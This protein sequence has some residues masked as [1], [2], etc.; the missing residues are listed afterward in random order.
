MPKYVKNTLFIAVIILSAYTAICGYM[1]LN[2][3]NLLFKPAIAAEDEP[4]LFP[5]DTFNKV[6]I[7]TPEGVT[8]QGIASEQQKNSPALVFFAGN[9]QNLTKFG[10]FLRKALPQVNLVGFNYQG[11]G[12]SSG[13]ATTKTIIADTQHI[14]NWV[15]IQS[16]GSIYALG[17]SIGTG[18]A[19]K[20]VTYDGIKGLFL[21]MPYNSLAAIGAGVYPWLPV[22]AIFKDNIHM[23]ALLKNTTKPVAIVT[24][25]K[26]T[27]IPTYHA[28]KLAGNIQNL[29]NF[30][31][32]PGKT[33][34]TLIGSA[35]FAQWLAPTFQKMHTQQ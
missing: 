6:Y 25:E 20:F 3:S 35:A 26:D 32:L 23:S 29:V 14:Y 2:Q 9:A 1:F 15:K 8:L 12:Q 28:K 10:L 19:A 4:A 5:A 18:P 11:Y 7:S 30:T 33:H 31:T 22:E 13:A 17:L 24:A 16:Y 21:A 34:S 27:L